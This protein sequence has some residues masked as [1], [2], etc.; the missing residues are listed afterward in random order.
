MALAKIERGHGKDLADVD[1]RF[2]RAWRSV[3][4]D[5]R[6]GEQRA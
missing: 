3:S 1:E 2:R 4:S 6:D 5:G